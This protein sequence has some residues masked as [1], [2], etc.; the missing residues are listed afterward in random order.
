MYIS[1]TRLILPK[2]DLARRILLFGANILCDKSLHFTTT[3]VCRVNPTGKL[4]RIA[5]ISIIL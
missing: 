4:R 5:Y 3:F 2:V 1:A